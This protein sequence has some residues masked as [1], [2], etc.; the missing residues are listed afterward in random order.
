MSGAALTAIT[1]FRLTTQDPERLALFYAGI[2]FMVG[3]AE[4]ISAKELLLLGLKGGGMRIPLRL[5]RQRVDLDRFDRPGRPYPVLRNAADIG[6][7]H[8]ALRTDDARSE[9]TRI[10][11]EGA[12]PISHGG[13][14]TLSASSGGVTAIKFRDPEGHPLELLEFP[15]DHW[16]AEPGNGLCGIA[17]SAISVADTSVSRR[18]YEAMGLTVRHSTLNHGPTQAQLDG[19]EGVEVDVVALSPREPQPSLELLHYR[20]PRGRP[21][22]PLLPNDVAA[23]RIVWAADR[24]ALLRDPDGHLHLLQ[25]SPC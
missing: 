19:I 23:T 15:P 17:H 22:V 3:E 1:A 5:G 24:D 2:G 6:F 20:T 11:G 7:Q 10:A 4:P 8:L 25:R 12:I 21:S 18:F 16:M 13:P 14:V 9:W